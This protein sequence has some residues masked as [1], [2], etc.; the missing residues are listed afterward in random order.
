M[1]QVDP[2]KQAVKKNLSGQK[3][4]NVRKAEPS[5]ETTGS[6]GANQG[7][8]SPD[9]AGQSV[10]QK[11]EAPGTI[12]LF[13]QKLEL[14]I[15]KQKPEI[16]GQKVKVGPQ[17]GTASPQADKPF[18]PSG[19]AGYSC[20]DAPKPA[21]FEKTDEPRIKWNCSGPEG[22][23]FTVTSLKPY[24]K[25]EIKEDDDQI[26]PF[27]TLAQAPAGGLDLHIKTT[28]IAY[29]EDVRTNWSYSSEFLIDFSKCDLFKVN[30]IIYRKAFS[31]AGP[32]QRRVEVKGNIL[33]VACFRDSVPI[34]V[35]APLCDPKAKPGLCPIPP[36][37]S[38]PVLVNESVYVYTTSWHKIFEVASDP[39]GSRLIPA[40]FLENFLL[41]EH[42][43][44]AVN[45]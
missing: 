11:T 8:K 42:R 20:S 27:L 45:G 22:K 34:A 41:D 16:E 12:L 39:R 2:G 31:P 24:D 18:P 40:D 1:R 6:G 35:S 36:E 10:N 7:E 25:W 30:G 9:D 32:A 21:G 28:T 26:A 38:S 29:E 3:K 13:D 5:T 37:Q 4:Q 43:V 17:A 14:T 15:P 33:S 19:Q 23:K 44:L